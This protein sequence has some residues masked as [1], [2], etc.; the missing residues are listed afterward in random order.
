MYFVYYVLILHLSY[1]YVKLSNSLCRVGICNKLCTNWALNY[2]SCDHGEEKS[3]LCASTPLR[4]KRDRDA[5]LR[6]AAETTSAIHPMPNILRIFFCSLLAYCLFLPVVS[7]PPFSSKTYAYVAS[8][9]NL[10]TT[11]KQDEFR[12]S[13]SVIY[14][15]E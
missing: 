12:C 15:V 13:L 10:F 8:K 7:Q 2:Q 5:T 11:G 14:C 4:S 9:F 3:F 6:P 1:L